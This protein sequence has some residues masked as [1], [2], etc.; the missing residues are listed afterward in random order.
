V[1]LLIGIRTDDDGLIVLPMFR[2][3]AWRKSPIPTRQY[4]ALSMQQ[5]GIFEIPTRMREAWKGSMIVRIDLGYCYLIAPHRAAIQS[6]EVI[7][8]VGS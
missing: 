2:A 5:N 6:L 3:Q 4:F 8:G 7:R 1:L